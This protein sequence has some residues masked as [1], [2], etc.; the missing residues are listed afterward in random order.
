MSACMSS[1]S[2]LVE[3]MVLSHTCLMGYVKTKALLAPAPLLQTGQR[4]SKMKEE[5]LVP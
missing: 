5:A 1:D 4:S 2:K 3:A